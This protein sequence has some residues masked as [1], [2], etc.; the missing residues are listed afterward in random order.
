MKSSKLKN[1]FKVVSDAWHLAKP[2]WTG[3]EKGKAISLLIAIIV[4]SLLEV[5]MS[6]RLNKWNVGFYNAIQ[7]FDKPGFLKALYLFSILIFSYISVI[8]IGFYFSS[9]LDV[10]WRKWL[11]NFYINDWF[12]SKTYYRSRFTDTYLDNPDQRI[13]EDIREFVQ[14][15][16]SLFFGIFKSVITLAS[17][18][19][20]LW[21][22]SGN[23]KF[24]LFNHK[25]NIPGYMVW[26]AVLYAFIGTYIM[27][28]IGRPLIK[29]NYQQQMYEADFR[30]NLVRV[31]EY[32]EHVAS[33]NGDEIEKKIIKK[34]FDNI[35]SNFIQTLKRNIKIS[36]FEIFYAQI[37]NIVPFLIA[38]G[39]Y[40]SKEIAFGS[41]M[42]IGSAFGSV[43]SS[44]SYFIFS[45]KMFAALRAV[46]DRLLGFKQTIED[47]G[48]LPDVPIISHD[49][50]YIEVK[51]LQIKLPDGQSLIDN[52]SLTLHEGERLLI[53]GS[54]G[55]GKTILLKALNGL[56]PY[57]SGEIH[58]NLSS[59]SLFISQKP[60]LPRTNLKEAICYPKFVN[61]PS[62]NEVVQILNQCGLGNLTE[63][64]YEIKNWDN[65][66]SLGEQ[67]KI[68]FCRVIINKPDVL[69]LD[70]I[71]S[72]L[73]EKAES[74]L[75]GEIIQLLPNSLIISIG[76]RSTLVALHTKIINV[77]D[78][79]LFKNMN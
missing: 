77:T 46:M 29:L 68:A 2:Y 13:S 39:R 43:Q 28:K 47:V 67:Q 76:H 78:H 73:D 23:F 26:L 61:L 72:A 25:F 69:Y 22:L 59:S 12:G 57:V 79:A 71:T 4:F 3:S 27:F 45:Y 63:K 70:E 15:S 60:Y 40:F 34:D 32:A 38:G 51:N 65:Y 7:N 64:L 20:I 21:G 1:R 54:S 33:Y 74:Y 11:T 5:Y 48:L 14:L 58:K 19:I 42:Q 55:A 49:K 30:Y 24:I 75:Y 6:V 10:R 36:L 35:V 16:H 37:S 50:N 62:D 66:L 31:R 17:F 18:A 52:F 56:W 44:I 53:Q 8:V 9:I 41:L